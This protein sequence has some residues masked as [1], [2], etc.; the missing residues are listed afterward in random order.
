[1][2]IRPS[3]ILRRDARKLLARGDVKNIRASVGNVSFT[4]HGVPAVRRSNDGQTA[5]YRD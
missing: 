1:M 2:F 5:A 4:G 3:R